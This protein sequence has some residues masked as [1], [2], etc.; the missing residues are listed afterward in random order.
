MLHGFTCSPQRIK[1]DPQLVCADHGTYEGY[2]DAD[3]LPS[4]PNPKLAKSRF[5]VLG[6]SCRFFGRSY[7]RGF[8]RTGGP[9]PAG[10]RVRRGFPEMLK[11]RPT[12][13]GR[14]LIE[15]VTA[16][17]R[18]RGLAARRSGACSRG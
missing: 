12:G 1:A 6:R 2:V 14:H 10:N 18:D 7:L 8:L 9:I 4:L 5:R 13:R 17:A 16:V 15:M 11:K 3:C